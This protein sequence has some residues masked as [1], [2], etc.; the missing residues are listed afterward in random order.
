MSDLLLVIE[1]LTAPL[2]RRVLL[3]I[4]KALLTNTNDAPGQQTVQVKALADELIDG[5]ERYQPYGLTSHA[6][7][8]AECL[9]LAV[10]GH[11]SHPVI[12]VIDDRRHRPRGLSQGEVQLYA[13]FGQRVHLRDDG[14]VEIAGGGGGRIEI[15]P[16]GAIDLVAAAGNFVKLRDDGAVEIRS[17]NGQS[18]IEVRNDCI[19]MDDP[20]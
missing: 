2:R 14:A 9:L 13:K 18:W 19:E 17:A 16:S 11:R 20:K 5:A 4:S 10:G 6:E 3:M 8:G 1:K 12:A 7:P 15:R